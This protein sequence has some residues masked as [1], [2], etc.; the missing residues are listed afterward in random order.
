M[1]RDRLISPQVQ[2]LLDRM[3]SH[4]E[5]FYRALEL[6]RTMYNGK[7]DMVLST[8]E[9]NHIEKFLIKRKMKELKREAT[10]RQIIMTIMYGK[11]ESDEDYHVRM[12][13]AG[14]FTKEEQDRKMVA[15]KSMVEQ[16]KAFQK[17]LNK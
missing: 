5:E 10:H 6:T 13:T 14:R 12:S 8:G 17:E 11:E 2:M 16:I 1:F 4:P 9:F 3:E 15:S 7:W